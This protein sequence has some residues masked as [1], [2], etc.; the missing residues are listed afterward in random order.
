MKP[1]FCLILVLLFIGCSETKEAPATR[2]SSP[3][4]AK[5][6]SSYYSPAPPANTL[7]D[8]TI[9]ST[10]Y[11]RDPSGGALD[12]LA[13]SQ[14]SLPDKPGGNYKVYRIDGGIVYYKTGMIGKAA[15]LSA[16]AFLSKFF[17]ITN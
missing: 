9:G 5:K 3:E 7:A 17:R 6:T 14:I 12:E 10:W 2:E 13:P 4:S 15:Q 16:S 1:L 8:I 11:A